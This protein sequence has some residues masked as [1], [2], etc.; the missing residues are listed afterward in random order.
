MIPL[1]NIVGI[2][3]F[4]LELEICTIMFKIYNYGSKYL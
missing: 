3:I 1:N 2:N 4:K